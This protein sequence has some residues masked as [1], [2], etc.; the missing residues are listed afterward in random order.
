[1]TFWEMHDLLFDNQF[2]FEDSDLTTYA[3]NLDLNMRQFAEDM[4]SEEIV[5]KVKDDFLSGVRS[6][7]N[8]T[9]T[10]FINGVRFD[11]PSEVEFLQEA[12]E[13]AAKNG[14]RKEE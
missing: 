13:S 4:K 3:Q 10:F 1:M 8:G 9:P 14:A 11:Q 7:V 5:K 6:G 12:I 2:A